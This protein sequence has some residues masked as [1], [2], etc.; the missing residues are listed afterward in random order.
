[1]AM[2][3]GEGRNTKKNRSEPIQSKSVVAFLQAR[4][5]STRL[6]GKVLMSIQGQ[7]NLERA[8][9]RLRAAPAIDEVAVLTTQCREDDAIVEESHK[10]GTW[11]YRGPELD[12]LTR[13]YEAYEKF[14]PEIIIRATADN[15]LIDIGS[16]DRIVGTL[17]EGNLDLC[18]ESELP[19][20]AATEALTA[21]ALT[22][23]HLRAREAHHRE[24]VTLYMKE[25]SEEFCSS[26]PI[27]PEYLRFPQIRLTVDTLE[28][29]H[30]VSQLI[31]R[32]PEGP[33]P[34]PLRE[35]LPLALGVLS[36]GECKA[37]TAS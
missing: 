37:L 34:L 6:P 15:P 29:L 33:N 28:D 4:M 18:M 1:M 25:H 9:R 21:E 10:L 19:Y 20:G 26:F 11:V 24:H 35:Y 13:F 7:S 2:P 27:P 32:L 22:R 5:G 16:I 30:F 14:R 3:K 36:E 31:C 23:V 8:I 12:V 17:R